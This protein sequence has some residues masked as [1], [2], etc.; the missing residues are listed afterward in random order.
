ME[1]LS[2]SPFIEV[3]GA[4]RDG[5]DGLAMAA[6]LKP[7]VI[8]CDLTMP[9]MDGVEFVR[10]QMEVCPVPILMLTSAPEDCAPALAAIEAGAVDFVQKPTASASDDLRKV[11]EEL[12]EKVKEAARA[13]KR[14]IHPLAQSAVPPLCIR[15]ASGV[16]VV[17]LGIS[18]GG[19]QALRYLIPQFPED[20]PAPVAVVLHMPEGYT[21]LF[22]E[23][24][25][26]ISKLN[27][28]EASQNQPLRAGTVAI[29][30]AGMHL[31]LKKGLDGAPV[32][33]LTLNPSNKP[34][35]PSVD[36]LF[37]S[38]AESFGSR[39]LAIVMTGMGD[40]G[41]EGAAWVKSR[42]GI[43][44]TEAEESCIVFG[45]PRAVA[46]SG[47]SDGAYPLTAMAESISRHL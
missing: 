28:I 47:L 17:V 7:D 29:A 36:V 40:D 4:A 22:A 21:A 24:L 8:T 16:D 33:D 44:L 45:M 6:A 37:Q 38:A 35:R 23:K 41:R 46:E 34:H 42:G 15:Q 1:M 25:N 31:R 5:E 20:F 27:V 19:P 3:V 14:S 11:R 9:R 43:V 39:V 26:A 12:K 13:P 10:R 2:G 32:M 30:K 18:T